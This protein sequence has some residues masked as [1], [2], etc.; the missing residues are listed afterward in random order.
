MWIYGCTLTG[1]WF[2]ALLLG[3]LTLWVEYAS[4]GPR[5]PTTAGLLQDGLLQFA[6]RCGHPGGFVGLK[7]TLAAQPAARQ[8]RRFQQYNRPKWDFIGNLMGFNGDLIPI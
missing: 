5:G 8:H 2:F 6:A 7:G 3:G 4:I 1:W